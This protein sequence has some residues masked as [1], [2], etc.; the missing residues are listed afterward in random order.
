MLFTR[1]L[2]FCLENINRTTKMEMQKE[3]TTE[4]HCLQEGRETVE[5][6][7]SLKCKMPPQTHTH[8]HTAS[9]IR[10]FHQPLC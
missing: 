9:F 7:L 8:T 10:V 4:N 6:S 2:I 1:V 3:R 5:S